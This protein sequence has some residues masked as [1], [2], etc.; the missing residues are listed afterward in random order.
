MVPE[1]PVVPEAQVSP[2]MDDDA[3][4]LVPSPTANAVKL[5]P[6]PDGEAVADDESEPPQAF[7][8]GLIDLSLLPLYLDHTAK[9]I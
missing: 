7:E 6:P 9:H 5:V 2:P 8:G 3:S 4:E 1:S